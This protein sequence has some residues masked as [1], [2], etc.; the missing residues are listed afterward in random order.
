MKELHSCRGGISGEHLISESII[1]LL[2]GDGEFRISGTPWL[3]E[4]EWKVV[5]P[6]S[7]TA[8]CLCVR[9]NG[10]LHPFD[11]AALLL[12]RS[13]KE[14]LEREVESKSYLISGHDIERWLL[15]TLKALAASGNLASGR[16]RLAGE[17]AADVRI[18]DM[19]SDVHAWPR[20]AGLYCLMEAG[21][22]MINHNHFQIA[23][24]TNKEGEINGLL[25]NI[26]G[27]NFVLLL[28]PALLPDIPQLAKAVFR[29]GKITVR[30]P[31]CLN[32]VIMSWDDG[33]RHRG[34]LQLSFVRQV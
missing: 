23:P 29:P 16:E 8:K 31:S 10:N 15:K 1:R 7:L 27:I 33:E 21:D 2:A 25:T 34:D 19:L 24:L 4:G 6:K 9:H 13:L 20:G 26:V 18:V 11:D 28:Q 5:G 17:F 12:F 14:V 30:Q 22:M 32:E 3:A